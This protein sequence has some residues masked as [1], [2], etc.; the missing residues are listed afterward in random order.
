MRIKNMSFTQAFG[1]MAALLLMLSS[2]AFAII[3]VDK[4]ATDGNDGTSWTDA[5]TDLVS[6]M[7]ENTTEEIWV[8][9]GSYDPDSDDDDT[10]KIDNHPVY[11]G[12]NGTETNRSDRQR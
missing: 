4:D 6:A 7:N 1:L 10:F 9:A 5:Y 3:Y 12:F 2:P 8:A 11:G